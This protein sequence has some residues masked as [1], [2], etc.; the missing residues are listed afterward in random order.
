MY[1]NNKQNT[2]QA[3]PE[4]CET[5]SRPCRTGTSCA[6]ALQGLVVAGTAHLKMAALSWTQK[7]SDSFATEL[8]SILAEDSRG[9]STA[10]P[11]L[12]P[13]DIEVYEVT[14]KSSRNRRIA[15]SAVP[16]PTAGG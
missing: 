12:E 14:V 16:P 5:Q 1:V 11:P 10:P 8:A 7:M 9:E 15:D 13:G 3:K 2:K 4:K 6:E